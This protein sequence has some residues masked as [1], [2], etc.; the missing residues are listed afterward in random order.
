MSRQEGMAPSG[1]QEARRVVRLR[2]PAPFPCS[3]SR[4]GLKKWLVTDRQGLGVVYDVSEKGARVM[5][6]AAISPGDQ[7]ALDLRLPHQSSSMFVEL[8]T[9]RWGND[10]T[11]GVEFEDLSPVAGMRLKKYL[12]RLSKPAAALN[13]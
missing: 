1:R 8:A 7:L 10:R 6:E 9:V 11:F 2:V 12:I 13:S 4:V 5:T 3:F